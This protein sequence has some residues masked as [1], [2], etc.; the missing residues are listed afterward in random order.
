MAVQQQASASLRAMPL[1]GTVTM[2]R[3][4]TCQSQV[5]AVMRSAKPCRQYRYSEGM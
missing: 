5:P 3:R 4:H 2:R 1:H